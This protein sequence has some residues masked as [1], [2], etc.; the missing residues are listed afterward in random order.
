VAERLC[1]GGHDVRYDAAI[2]G[3]RR[4]Y[5]DDPWGNRLELVAV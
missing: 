1:A 4:F 2:P 5:T 3:T